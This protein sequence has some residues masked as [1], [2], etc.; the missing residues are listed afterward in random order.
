MPLNSFPAGMRTDGHEKSRKK[1]VVV[2][3]MHRSG[4][5][6]IT[7]GLQVLGVSLGDS[8]MPPMENINNK[9]F[10]ED[11]D[12]NALNVEML[13]AVGSDWHFLAPIE[14]EDVGVL[15]K[16]GYFLRAVDLLLRK[17]GSASV[18]GLKDP[19]M[20]KLL[21]F[22]SVV[23]DHCQFSVSYVMA[24]R[25][26]L[27]VIQSLKK[28]DGFEAEKSYFLWLGYVV[29][30][31][32]GMVTRKSVIVD[33][34]LLM[35]SPG[36]ELQRIARRLDLSV[37]QTELQDY[38]SEFLD[39]ALRHTFFDLNDLLLDNVCPPLVREM[40]TE[41]LSVA[42]DK[43]HVE[44]LQQK[45]KIAHWADEFIRVKS[46][47]I[48]ADKLWV[49]KESANQVIAKR[50]GQIARF[51]QAV[52]ERDTRIASLKQVVM[53][54]DTTIQ[55]IVNSRSWLLTKPLRWA[56]R[57]VRGDFA[58][59]LEPLKKKLPLARL[60]V[61]AAA[62]IQK[63][64]P[65]SPTHPVAVILPIYRNVEMTRRCILAAMPGVL[66]VPDARLVAIN[67]ASPD[68]GMQEM[69]DEM[70][71]RWPGVLDVLGNS[72]NLGFVQTVNRGIASFPEHD[73]VLLNS[74]V[75]VPQ[76]WLQRLRDEAYS[77]SNVGT[78]TPFSNNAT[79]CSFPVFLQEN[80]QPF[81]LD[82]D[83][84]DA[85]FRKDYLPCVEAPTGV[86]FCMYI[87][88]ACLGQTGALD[89]EKFG[90]GYGE[91][92]DLC[93]RALKKGWVNLISPNIYAFHEGGVSFSSSK[94]AL[95]ERAMRVMDELHP[96]YHADVQAFI[97]DDP[98]RSAR[99]SRYIQ[100]LSTIE[101]PKIL[102]VFHGIGGGVEQHID[103]LAQYFGASAAFIVLTPLS[104][105]NAV[106]VSFSVVPQA[107]RLI[108]RSQDYEALVSLMRTIGLTAVH[109]H[110]TLGVG[111]WVYRL[112]E[113]IGVGYVMTAHDFYWINGNPTLT[114]E[115]G[116]FEGGNFDDLLNPLYP[117]PPGVGAK[118]WRDGLRSL[119]EG[120]ACVIFPSSTTKN[121]FTG[122][123]GGIKKTIVAAHV[124]D[125]RNMRG[126]VHP[127]SQKERYVIGVLG[128]LGREKGADYL[129]EIAIHAQ[130]LGLPFVF[131]LIGY[132]YRPLQVVA[133]TGPYKSQDMKALI[134]QHE[135][136]LVFFPALWP[137]TYSYTL[138]YAIE[139]GLPVVAPDIGA[140]PERL[141][142][143][144]HIMLYRPSMRPPEFLDQ[145]GLFINGLVEGN[146]EAAPH[147][148]GESSPCDFY[149]HC[150]LEALQSGSTRQEVTSVMPAS[151]YQAY[152][153][154]GPTGGRGVRE[155]LLRTL[156]R[157]YMNPS[158][159]WISK[160]I[161][162]GARRAVKRILSR[163]PMHDVSEDRKNYYK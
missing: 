149:A 115:S 113:D 138:S 152:L 11:A 46:S 62:D 71:A 50:D 7:R 157:L 144:P 140:F 136:D 104:D 27:S 17:V 127:F 48:L 43:S 70:A 1:L 67:D 8:L 22:W 6:A 29:A 26:P 65:I 61:A 19:R 56:G 116:K 84:I 158:F 126:P 163:R 89:A 88:R 49:Q 160:V 28:R 41:L 16:Q 15:R 37:D 20:A 154:T 151:S 93:Q 121:I 52:V 103:E 83:A 85:V 12:L 45:N 3:G 135:C 125:I 96:N 60:K 108:F 101:H 123:Y 9:G 75:I 82:V 53:E 114:N 109:F 23:F 118:A 120:A 73:V 142:G 156:W 47:L 105:R 33:Y 133:C 35:Q 39:K 129:E 134:V 146:T 77:R 128:A 100:L 95:V 111:N 91:E 90:R 59:A 110:H 122:F 147:Y 141:S 130:R 38:K 112:P 13:A 162:F 21:P 74:D 72:S 36:N 148:A 40:Y 58:A 143:R 78:V 150:Y 54:H 51:K 159:W 25:H 30:A 99:T 107:D 63:K 66:S 155:I 69:L 24:V 64:L 117:L 81:G 5:S 55:G 132:A 68:A 131:K 102:H 161:P 139:S 92:N 34:D 145:L 137:E 2:L 80:P 106:G 42:S 124:E 98:L 57:V 18:F 119:I 14:S 87:R 86:G 10:W 97:K 94:Q 44:D 4:T 76:D 153:A 79:I 31:L 32:S